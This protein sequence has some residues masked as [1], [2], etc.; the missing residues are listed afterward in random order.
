M[1]ATNTCGTPIP[2]PP[3]VIHI[4]EKFIA[5]H[6]EQE[7]KDLVKKIMNDYARE[8]DYWRHEHIYMETQNA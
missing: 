3:E 7:A 4:S 8:L 1:N 6:G 2:E 5:E